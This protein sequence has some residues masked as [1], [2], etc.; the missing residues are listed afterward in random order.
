MQAARVALEAQAARV[1]LAVEL[2]TRPA[3]AEPETSLAEALARLV[4]VALALANNATQP[5]SP[6]PH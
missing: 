3:V 5:V 6:L 1:V 4:P 2:A